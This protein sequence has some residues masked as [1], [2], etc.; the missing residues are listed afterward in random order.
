MIIPQSRF[1]LVVITLVVPPLTVC[2]LYENIMAVTII[3]G[4]KMEEF[5]RKHP[6]SRAPLDTWYRVV[7]MSDWSSM[8]EMKKSLPSADCI[9]DEK[10]VFNVGGNKY[11]LIAWVRF[12]Q[13]MVVVDEILTH[14]EYDRKS[15]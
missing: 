1:S 10:F 4:R 13:Q 6:Q 9:S 11:R 12:R 14:S 3:A 8:V 7:S 15:L 2:S 5:R